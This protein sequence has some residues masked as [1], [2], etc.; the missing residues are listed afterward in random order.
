MEAV[1]FNAI[2]NL[3]TERD[4]LLPKIKKF[5]VNLNDYVNQEKLK[6]LLVYRRELDTFERKVEGIR[7]AI[8]EILNKWAFS[9]LYDN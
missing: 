8:Y 1:I 2:S 5:L 9:A 3:E 4:I 7:K 6:N